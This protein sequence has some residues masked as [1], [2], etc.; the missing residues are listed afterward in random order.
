MSK[1][2]QP[3]DVIVKDAENIALSGSDL[4]T[5]TEGKANIIKYSDLHQYSSIDDVFGSKESIIILYL[6]KSNFGHWCCL[7]KAPWKPETLYFYDSYGFQ[8]DEE[9]KFADEQLRIHQGQEVP[10]LTHLIRKSNYYLEQNDFQ[11]QSKE[12]HINT[13]G[14]W[15]GM[16]VRHMDMSPTQ[17]KTFFTKN[18]HYTPDFWVS[19]LS[20]PS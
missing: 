19:V 20:I 14:R 12:H 9:I 3:L 15:A 6:K 17:F 2:Q 7:F 18:K 5:I 10:H 16:R 13:C 11:Y 8:L 4:E 1:K